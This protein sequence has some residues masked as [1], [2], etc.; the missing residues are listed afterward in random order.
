MALLQSSPLEKMT[1]QS[2]GTP[3]PPP[4]TSTPAPSTFRSLTSRRSLKQISLFAVGATFLGLSTLITRRSLHRRYTASLPAFYR[5][6]NAPP[7]QPINGGLEALEALNIAT[8]N[9]TSFMIMMAGGAAWAF[10]VSSVDDLRKRISW[11]GSG[12]DEGELEEELQEWVAGILERK[13][14]KEERRRGVDAGEGRRGRGRAEDD[15]VEVQPVDS[16]RG[17]GPR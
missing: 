14:G 11:S 4:S 2:T 9:V 7:A 8:I 12:R 6:S 1:S 5:P 16:S 13:K 10:D 3:S 17:R 15:W